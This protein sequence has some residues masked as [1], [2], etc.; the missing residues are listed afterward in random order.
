MRKRLLSLAAAA[1]VL[2]AACGSTQ[3]SNPPASSAPGASGAPSA[4]AS[5]S[6]APA[7]S[8]DF[9]FSLNGEPTYFSPSS[10]DLPTA[11]I[12]G[13][14]YTAAYRVNNKGEVIPDLATAMPEVSADG[15]TLTFKVRDDAKWSDGTPVTADDLL[16]TYQIA[17]S[18][19]C[20]FNPTT[21]STWHDNVASVSQPTP[22][23]IQVTL[24]APYAPFY[25]LGLAPT[26]IVPKAATEAS[27][28]KFVTGSGG[29]DAA[30][31]KA[32]VDK[33]QAAQGD[34]GCSADPVPAS[35]LSSTYIA[36][37]EA[38]L[39]AAGIPLLDKSRFT[40]TDANGN[41]QPDPNAY[42][43]NALVQLTDL[44][45]TLQAGETDKIAAA[46]RLLDINLAPVGSG[47][48]KLGTYA[49]GQSVE[50][51]RNDGYY[52]FTPGPAKVLI[53]IIKDAAAEADALS[54]GNTDWITEIT[55]SDSL[56]K[57]KADPNLKL[58]EYPDLGYYF[59]AFNVRPGHVFSDVVTRQA[60]AMCIDQP[61][62]VQ[63]AT[64]GNGIGVKAE[65]PPGSFYYN[66]AVPDYKHDVAGAK[67]LLEGAG[68]KLNS[69]NVYEKNGKPLEATLYVRQGRPQR[70][71]FAELARDQVAECGI[72]LNVNEADFAAVLLPLLSYPN[73]FDI[74]LG[75]W[76]SLLDPEDSN[77]FGCDHVTTKDNPDDNNF[78]GYCDKA[79]DDL[80]AKAKAELDP[81][82]RK[83][84]L[85]DLQVK[86][87]NDGPYYFL[88]ADLAHKGY[89][90][91]VGTNGEE[92]PIDYTTFYDYWNQDSWTV[93][94]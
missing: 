34:A 64:E 13:L 40:S 36:D 27:Y 39:N 55:S 79:V 74:Y 78:T 37:I 80:L 67:A 26:L 14:L 16:F 42:A 58:S 35:C 9:R 15:L 44:N 86:L 47:P 88:W 85:A 50:L 89:S 91:K 65:V 29:V 23:T 45:T 1:V 28:Q 53:P 92:G 17:L 33:I 61:T 7:G 4:A 76:A 18:E 6:A 68:Y 49:P 71:K 48:Y 25:I 60:L 75:G 81:Q 66:D 82:K 5:A 41:V 51:D 21:C 87:H 70:V 8:A 30:A 2:A 32:L 94:Q 52:L 59:M 72:K 90:N 46:Y 24:K 22:G 69:D 73:N 43:D 57:L 77:I 3:S 20:S 62:T 93:A 56:A 38:Q 54:S 11:W 83:A 10:N 63:V 84:I 19:K 31:V 12:D